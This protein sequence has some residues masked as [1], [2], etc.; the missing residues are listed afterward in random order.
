M[1][2]IITRIL[3]DKEYVLRRNTREEVLKVLRLAESEFN[4]RPRFLNVAPGVRDQIEWIML[5]GV[6]IYDTPKQRPGYATAV[7]DG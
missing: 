4:R 1:I 5:D 3:P 2:E 7:W 6:S